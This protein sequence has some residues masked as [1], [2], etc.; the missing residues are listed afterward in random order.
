MTHGPLFRVNIKELVIIRIISGHDGRVSVLVI[1]CTGGL[2]ERG[3]E[4]ACL[5][6]Q[7]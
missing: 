5:S 2:L 1:P 4:R 7:P 3:D 6:E